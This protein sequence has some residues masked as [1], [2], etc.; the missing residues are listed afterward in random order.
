[1]KKIKKF[2]IVAL[3]AVM[4]ICVNINT[5][6]SDEINKYVY[7][8]GEPFGLKAFSDGVMIVD[9]E[10]F[11][12][13]E[14]YVCPAE[15]CG[16][17]KS[18]IITKVNGKEIKTNEDFKSF[19]HN[20]QGESLTL[21]IER[22]N[23]EYE[24]KIT[25]IKNT[26]DVYLIGAWIRDSSAGIGTVT[27]YDSEK[28]Y[29]AALGHGICDSDTGALIPLDYGEAVKANIISTD[30]S[31]PGKP[32]NLNGY[33]SE[34]I[35]GKI[36]K[37]TDI[38][39]FGKT[40]SDVTNIKQKVKVS[41]SSDVKIGNATLCTTIIDDIPKEYKVEIVSINKHFNSQNNNFVIKITDERLIDEAGGIVQGMSGSPIIQ[42]G[43]LVGAVTHVLINDPTKGYGIFIEN[44]ME[45]AG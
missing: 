45:A 9:I 31:V 41:S 13:G 42:N 33:F 27:Y 39:I 4:L 19:T 3:S 29:F 23:K 20:C 36:E 17:K 34:E 16:L 38:G 26:V 8:G 2:I 28:C 14:K 21:T 1:M 43:K 25:P 15:K 18:D 30:K 6:K 35:L 44:M 40:K 32:G 22:D 5:V 11:Y 24:K 37:N 7:L 10:S 12:D